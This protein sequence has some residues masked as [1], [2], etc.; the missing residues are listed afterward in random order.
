MPQVPAWPP[1]PLRP[2]SPSWATPAPTL[3]MIRICTS[4]II[5]QVSPF[6]H[7]IKCFTRPIV[8]IN[9][10]EGS[11]W[12][13]LWQIQVILIPALLLSLSR[14]R[15]H[16]KHC[17]NKIEVRAIFSNECFIWDAICFVWL[18][19]RKWRSASLSMP[20]AIL[21]A[22]KTI[23]FYRIAQHCI[24]SDRHK[25]ALSDAVMHDMTMFTL[26]QY[27]TRHL[28]NELVASD[29]ISFS[30]TNWRENWLYLSPAPK[31][32]YL[33]PCWTNIHRWI[34]HPSDPGSRIK[35]AGKHRSIFSCSL[36]AKQ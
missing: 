18:I 9:C 11:T 13:Q 34:H 28:Q 3:C 29:T 30:L 22:E 32:I 26:C 35:C 17:Y 12:C 19:W 36:C 7:S 15:E 33:Q 10:C 5:I 23:A 21:N 31:K 27:Q 6:P 4:N 8:L 24:F 14:L 2:L 16:F 25:S 1:R 20:R